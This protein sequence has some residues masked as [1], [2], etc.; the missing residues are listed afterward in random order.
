MPGPMSITARHFANWAPSPRYS[1]R[2]SRSPSSPSVM[3]SP[4]ENGSGFVPLSTL[5]PGSAPVLAITLTR[6]VPSFALWRIVSS[7]RMTPEM[8]LDMASVARK[9]S[10]RS[11]RRLSGVDSTPMESK[12]FLMVPDDSSAARMP[13]PGATIAS[14]ILLSSARFIAGSSFFFPIHSLHLENFHPRQ[15]PAF[16][17][18]EESAA[19]SRDIGKPLRRSCGVQCRYGI[20]PAR[21][22]D[23]V[24]RAREF[25]SRFRDFDRAD[26]ARLRAT[27]GRGG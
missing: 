21:D 2:R 16:H 7:Y 22:A 5:M 27:L 12:R 26:G 11:S 3:T 1:T 17:P 23:K 14:A 25:R 10:S 9:R 8:H 19:R 13:R 4:G 18:F 20:A 15:A 6:G 24:A